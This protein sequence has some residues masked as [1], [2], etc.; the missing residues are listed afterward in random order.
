VL[1]AK[2]GVPM[3]RYREERGR[4]VPMSPR[5]T[6]RKGKDA[7]LRGPAEGESHL[8]VLRYQDGDHH[9]KHPIHRRIRGGGRRYRLLG[10]YMG[11][12]DC[13]HQIGICFPGESWRTLAFTDADLHKEGVGPYHITFDGPGWKGDAW[14]DGMREIPAITKAAGKFCV[15][16]PHNDQQHNDRLQAQLTGRSSP[17]SRARPGHN[18]CDVVYFL[19][20][21]STASD[22]APSSSTRRAG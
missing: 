7:T 13:G 5:V 4:L 10:V 3:L 19:D 8:L 18:S 2:L 14:W 16:D 21:S 9:K 1:C 20:A 22:D 11:Q 12:R 6:D 17:S 15:I